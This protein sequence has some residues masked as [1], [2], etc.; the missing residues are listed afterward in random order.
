M[1]LQSAPVRPGSF[2]HWS[3]CLFRSHKQSARYMAMNRR[4][5][6]EA[7]AGGTL[8]LPTLTGQ[9]HGNRK[10]NLLYILVDQL[11]GLALPGIDSN[12]RMPNTQKLIGSGVMFSHAYTAGMTCAPSR[13]SL[14]TGLYTQTHGVGGGFRLSPDTPSLPGTLMSHGYT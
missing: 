2:R 4:S 9:N 6:L 14:D 12:A 3:G 1:L 11:S 7:A 10:P 5:F 8:A 13:A